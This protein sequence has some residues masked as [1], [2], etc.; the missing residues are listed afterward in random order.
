VAAQA[1][2]TEIAKRY[3]NAFFL[4][5]DEAKVIDAVADDLSVL[6]AMLDESHDLRRVFSNPLLSRKK[7]KDVL[8]ALA[9]KA[10]LH[11]L[12]SRFLGVLAENRRLAILN[13]I[14]NALRAEIAKRRGEVM[15]EVTVSSPLEEKQLEALTDALKLSL[16]AS[17]SLDIKT[18]PDILGGLIVRVGS[19]MI[20]GSVHTRLERLQRRL[21]SGAQFQSNE[22]SNVK[23]VA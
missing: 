5:A 8:G 2:Q 18:D 13:H 11:D 12:T 9:K 21:K 17:V 3:A 6:S 20:D 7:Q 14:I 16:G 4:L 10:E 19:R 22:Q 23:E 15:A 1:G